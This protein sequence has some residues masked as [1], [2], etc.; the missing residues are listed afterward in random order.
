LDITA[1]YQHMLNL[2]SNLHSETISTVRHQLDN[3]KSHVMPPV[4]GKAEENNFFCG[5][6]FQKF[7]K[8]FRKKF[9]NFFPENFFSKKF[10]EI[11]KIF[12]SAVTRV[13]RPANDPFLDYVER[14]MYKIENE[15][16]PYLPKLA[17]MCKLKKVIFKR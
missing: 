11:F 15:M 6:I 2:C 1:C 7:W 3:L 13:K 4:D 17:E 8:N 10:F 16:K 5:E 14:V 9:E 12:F